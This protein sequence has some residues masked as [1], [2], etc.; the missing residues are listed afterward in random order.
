MSYSHLYAL[1]ILQCIPAT[2]TAQAIDSHYPIA[3]HQTHTS[4]LQREVDK[5]KEK[6]TGVLSNNRGEIHR[7]Q[8]IQ[9]HLRRVD[10]IS[11]IKKIALEQIVEWLTTKE[12]LKT[13][14]FTLQSFLTNRTIPCLSFKDWRYPLTALVALM[15]PST[16][17]VDSTHTYHSHKPNQISG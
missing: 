16:S 15:P 14:A 17:Y 12:I 3:H 13:H 5:V 6:C 11:L 10:R 4:G 7:G 9:L 1:T 2:T 8:R